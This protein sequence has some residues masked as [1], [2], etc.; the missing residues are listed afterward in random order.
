MADA[1]SSQSTLA[2]PKRTRNGCQTCKKRRKRCDEQRPTCGS[3][4]KLDLHCVYGMNIR[5]GTT[6]ESF[7]NAMMPQTGLGTGSKDEL[8]ELLKTLD[9]TQRLHRLIDTTLDG[10]GRAILL[11]FLR[12]GYKQLANDI[13]ANDAWLTTQFPMCEHSKACL[14]SMLAF[15][16]AIDV[17]YD[18]VFDRYYDQALTQFTK[19]ACSPKPI[20]PISVFFAGLFMCTICLSRLMPYTN[21]LNAVIAMAMAWMNVQCPLA[22]PVL[23][24]M[25][26]LG[27]LDLQT[28]TINRLTPK[29]YTWYT[30]CRGQQGIHTT[31]GLPFSLIDLLSASDVENCE[32]ALLVWPIPPGTMAQQHLWEATRLAGILFA[33]RSRQMPILSYAL[34]EPVEI[35]SNGAII[36]SIFVS[37]QRCIEV[38]TE[39]SAQFKQALMFP[40][41]TAASFDYD[42]SIASKDFIRLTIG[43]LASERNHVLYK[44]ILEAIDDFWQ[45]G[46]TTIESTA[47]RREVELCLL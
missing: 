2:A 37:I 17:D 4:N 29:Q 3:C 46:D 28:H 20:S 12:T 44:G 7:E 36:N 40:L 35:I 15:Q 14:L 42:L 11:K 24:F 23:E 33:R 27:Y 5:W 43:N 8:Y 1:E 10:E 13:T 6:R 16:T 34:L 31:S 21:H 39:Q 22:P 19:E 18:D 32:P 45:S 30:Y 9:I 26:L 47:Q 25:S 38:V 41:V